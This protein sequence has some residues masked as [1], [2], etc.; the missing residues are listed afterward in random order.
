MRN[1]VL[2]E[3]F[4]SPVF[5]KKKKIVIYLLGDP[6]WEKTVHEVLSTGRGRNVLFFL[7]GIAL[8]ATFD[9]VIFYVAL[10]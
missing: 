2:L 7:Y 10:Q 5:L 1:H 4:N 6:N 9:S 3:R 8:K